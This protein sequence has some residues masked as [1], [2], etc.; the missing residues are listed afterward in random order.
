[1]KKI[2]L[3]GLALMLAGCAHNEH[4]SVITP[5]PA[6]SPYGVIVLEQSD[7]RT[8][9]SAAANVA[10]NA[11]EDQSAHS[12]AA[13]EATIEPIADAA[14][15]ATN[16]DAEGLYDLGRRY[17]EGDGL[18]KNESIGIHY[19]GLSAELGKDEAKRVLGLI[20]IRKNPNDAE[21]LEMLEEA[22]L[23]SNK[24]QMQLGFLYGNFAEPKLN[25]PERA[26]TLLEK[27]YEAGN[28]TAALYLSK[29]YVRNG[30]TAQAD[31]ALA[32]AAEHGVLK[33]QVEFARVSSAKG[34][35]ATAGK[36]YRKAAQQGDS[37]AMYEYA[38]GLIIRRFESTLN[39][40]FAHPGEVEAVVWFSLAKRH[41]NVKADEEL[42]NL[43]GVL[44]EL[45]R[46]GYTLDDLE[47]EMLTPAETNG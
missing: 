10:D 44:S 41:G 23:T 13:S 8:D 21:A 45:A 43:A 40:R 16:L 31:Q 1:M 22:A 3:S 39:G 18:E 9:D 47:S 24:A 28:A 6:H 25:S 12:Y 33:A 34:H 7:W 20:A 2:I 32:F 26:L 36:Y 38:N 37:T 14:V 15:D 19:M 11:P 4:S 46:T 29:L 30:H 42:K 5:N 17:I 27:A 35:H